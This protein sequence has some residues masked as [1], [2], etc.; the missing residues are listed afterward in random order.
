[1]RPATCVKL[2]KENRSLNESEWIFG[3]ARRYNQEGK[4]VRK[5]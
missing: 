3:V 1:M 5:N 4:N 2:T